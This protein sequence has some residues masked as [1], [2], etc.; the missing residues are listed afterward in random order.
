MYGC[1]FAEDG[2][3]MLSPEEIAVS[4]TATAIAMSKN[5]TDDEMLLI[6]AV[7]MQ[8]ADTLVTISTAKEKCAKMAEV[9]PFE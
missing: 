2:D 5:L 7:F 6:A 8:L 3:A 4:V 1:R 9:Q